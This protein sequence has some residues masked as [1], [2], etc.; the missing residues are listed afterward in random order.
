MAR[1]FQSSQSRSQDTWIAHRLAVAISV[2]AAMASF[3]A[4]AADTLYVDL[5]NQCPGDGSW[6]NPYCR[7]D[8]ALAFPRVYGANKVLAVKPGTYYESLIIPPQDSG[9]VSQPFVLLARGAVVLQGGD[10]CNPCV[11]SRPAAPASSLMLSAIYVAQDSIGNI[12]DDI[13]STYAQDDGTP[14]ITDLPNVANGTYLRIAGQDTAYVNF[15]GGVGP[16]YPVYVAKRRPLRVRAS[17]VVVSGFNIANSLDDGIAIGDVAPTIRNVRIQNNIVQHSTNQGIDVR[18]SIWGTISGNSVFQN[19]DHGIYLVSVGVENYRV[20]GNTS[21]ENVKPGPNRVA[22]GIRLGNENFRANPDTA[23]VG[24]HV[25]ENNTLYGNQDS[26]MEIDG[27]HG[28]TVRSNRSYMNGDHG[29]DH[30][31]ARGAKLI[32]NL[33]YRNHTDGIS[34]EDSC[35]GISIHNCIMMDNGQATDNEDPELEARENARWGFTADNNLYY[36][37]ART[38]PDANDLVLVD[39]EGGNQ[40]T[41]AFCADTAVC[42]KTIA[43]L[44][45][46]F[47]SFEGHGKEGDPKFVNGAGG[48]YRLKTDS[49]GVDAADTTASGWA[50][51]DAVGFARYYDCRL[52]SNTGT[53]SGSV[54]DIGPLEHDDGAPVI[55][56]VV[57]YNTA[58]VFWVA[59]GE[60]GD[61]APAPVRHEVYVNDVKKNVNTAPAPGNGVVETIGL[62]L[63]AT[64]SVYVITVDSDSLRAKSNT[65]SLQTCCGQGCYGTGPSGGDRSHAGR[66]EIDYR[67][68]LGWPRPNPAG[69]SVVVNWSIPL[70]KTGEAFELSLFDLAGRRIATI[71]KGHAKAGRFAEEVPLGPAG[72]RG[73]ANGVLF[74]RLK[75]GKEVLSRTVVVLR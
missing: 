20:V 19:G 54:G 6:N 23:T 14:S 60:T 18:R 66:E 32:G 37:P 48:D 12:T 3:P 40:Y 67:L 51:T 41:D 45:L 53:P 34:V 73:G 4:L 58:E 10:L 30:L 1:L 33:A 57:D 7:I 56:A 21:F 16:D 28:A 29:F 8:T 35:S 17:N 9:S 13:Q 42:F 52:I 47:G 15:G 75:I 38:G 68:E 22:N 39:F 71:A 24:N 70:A 49:P 50:P 27:S 46:H 74:L 26:G 55:D 44:R 36:R 43:Q 5:N 2:Y 63:C 69:G 25:V 31:Y 62:S 64:S 61:A 65:L 59:R 11:L 72:S